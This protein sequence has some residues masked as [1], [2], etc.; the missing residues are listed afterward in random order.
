MSTPFAT[1][2]LGDEQDAVA[3]DGS[4]VRLLAGVKAGG[5]AHFRLTAGQVSRAVTHRTV[6]EIWYVVAGKGEMW[7][8]QDGREEIVALKAGTSLTVPLGTHFQFRA[9]PTQSLDIVGVTMPPWPGAGEA[10][11][12]AGPWRSNA[13]YPPADS[14]IVVKLLRDHVPAHSPFC[15]ALLE[16]LRG[17]EFAPNIAVLLNVGRTTAHYHE[18]FDEVYFM[19]EGSITLR[20]FDAQAASLTEHTLGKLELCV[21]PRGVHHQISMAS[22]E[23]TLCVLCMPAFD[24]ADEHPSDALGAP[25]QLEPV[26]AQ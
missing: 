1:R 26:A 13:P 14:P 12:V 24:P 8:A 19:L 17:S 3:P 15:G 10:R 4:E 6:E 22:P 9:A 5:M 21:I 23:N 25:L 2:E 16:I 18:N 20:L 7:R 11:V